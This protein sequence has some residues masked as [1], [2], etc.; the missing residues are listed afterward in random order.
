MFGA[1]ATASWEQRSMGDR[2]MGYDIEL[3]AARG[4]R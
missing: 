3:M 4:A 1:E 2:R